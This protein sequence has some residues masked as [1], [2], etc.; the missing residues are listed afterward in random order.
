MTTSAAS[1]ARLEQRFANRRLQLFRSGAGDLDA[2]LALRHRERLHSRSAIPQ[3][4]PH[5]IQSAQ[6]ACFK[7]VRMQAIQHQEAAHQLIARQGI[8]QAGAG[9]AAG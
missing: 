4:G 3:R 7:I 6:D 5:F 1:G 2:Q 9:I 8:D